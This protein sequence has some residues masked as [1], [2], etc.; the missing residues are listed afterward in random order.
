MSVDDCKKTLEIFGAT[1]I[2]V[3]WFELSRLHVYP[4]TKSIQQKETLKMPS[5]K[6][7]DELES[8]AEGIFHKAFVLKSDNGRPWTKEVYIEFLDVLF[9]LRVGL[10]SP[11]IGLLCGIIPLQGIV[12]FGAYAALSS[13]I[14]YVICN[15]VVMVDISSYG[16]DFTLLGE[17][18]MQAGAIFVLTWIITFTAIH[19]DLEPFYE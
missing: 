7:T 12:G 17:G 9:W 14:I 3:V 19:S 18:F 16:G 8:E 5:N 10:L 11:T 1:T 4:L 13:L 2:F 6:K 15:Q